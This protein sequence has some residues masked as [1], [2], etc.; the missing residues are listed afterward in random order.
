MNKLTFL[1][2]QSRARKL[3]LALASLFL[4]CATVFGQTT[5][6][7]IVGSVFDPTGAVV[8]GAQVTATNTQTGVVTPTTTSSTGEYRFSNLLVGTYNIS[9]EAGGFVKKELTNVSVELNAT[10]TANATL[11]IAQASTSVEVSTTAVAIDTTTAQIQ[12]TFET[13]ELADLPMASTGSGV[14][15]LSLL[16]AG[17]T[18]SGGVGAGMGPSVGGQR[19]RNNNFTIEGID[20]NSG[21]VTGP[22]VS[23]PNDAVA[24]FSVIQNQF[25]PDFGH[26][27]GGQFNQVVKSGTNE[28]HGAAYEYFENRNLNAADNLNAVD[29]TPLHPRF[30]DNRFGGDIGGPIKRN[31]LFF[32]AD[33][34]RNP[35]GEAGS[36]GLLYAPTQ[37]GYNTLATIPGINQ[38]NL[39]IL[40]QYLGTASTARQP[41][42]IRL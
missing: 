15:N 1:A 13:K 8:P 31:K 29:G 42:C 10:V 39:S 30:D 6:G 40:K 22:L 41:I 12:S 19:P 21:S 36:A 14:L 24:E 27:S 38:T 17:V 28:W 26:S 11:G 20:N 9:V 25:S 7:N 16:D 35:I 37:N 5:S 33:Y 2:G 18:T 3:I 23:V 34:E 4:A 32:F